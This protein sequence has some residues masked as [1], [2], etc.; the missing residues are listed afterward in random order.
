MWECIAVHG[1]M[2]WWDRFKIRAIQVLI[3]LPP[4]T[5]CTTFYFLISYQVTSRRR[6]Q[7]PLNPVKSWNVWQRIYFFVL[8]HHS[9]NRK[10]KLTRSTLSFSQVPIYF[11]S[12]LWSLFA[13]EPDPTT[14]CW[15]LE[16][17]KDELLWCFCAIRFCSNSIALLSAWAR[18]TW[19]VTF[20]VSY[21]RRR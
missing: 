17:W 13:F 7:K 12:F 9:T 15:P 5:G 8:R 20:S 21:L 6:Q 16:L 14:L 4:F 2:K 18:A 1:C 19:I 10:G 3:R 11:H